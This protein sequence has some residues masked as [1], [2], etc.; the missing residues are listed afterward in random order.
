[1]YE[2]ITL[3]F[4][5]DG[6]LC[7]IQKKEEQYIDLIPDEQM[8]EKYKYVTSG[9]GLKRT[10]LFMSPTFTAESYDSAVSDSSNVWFISIP[11]LIII[12]IIETY[13]FNRRVKKILKELKCFGLSGVEV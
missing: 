7:P 5:V 1:M 6:T 13:I 4:D 10:L 12:I 8:V 3:I 11:I 9:N 2:D